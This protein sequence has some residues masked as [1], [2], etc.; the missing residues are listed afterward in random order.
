LKDDLPISDVIALEDR[1]RTYSDG[2]LS[3][4]YI[5]P[6][7]HGSYVC[8]ISTFNSASV[9]SKPAIITVKCKFSFLFKFNFENKKLDPPIP[10]RHRQTK[11]LTLI[12]GS[13]GTCPCLLDAY[14]P[15]QSV[16]W[17]RNGASIRIEPKG[18]L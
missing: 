6:S 2:V 13:T 18:N 8:I 15:I 1:I 7:D 10:S 4:N 17:Y 3:I 14:P 11:N 5:E 9:R 12:R 16:S